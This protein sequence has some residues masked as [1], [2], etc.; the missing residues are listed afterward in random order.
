VPI[1]EEIAKMVPV[2]AWFVLLIRRGLEGAASD[3]AILGFAAGAGFTLHEDGLSGNPFVS[4]GGFLD[5]LPWSLVLPTMGDAGSS[6]ALNHGLWSAIVG[7]GVGLFFLLRHRAGAWVLPLVGVLLAVF[8]HVALN[9]LAG[10]PFLGTGRGGGEAGWAELVL[11]VTA[12]GL[13][14]LLALVIG[15]VITIVIET[16]ILS[17]ASEREPAFGAV[18]MARVLAERS[19]WRR[20]LELRTYERLRRR[21]FYAAWRA[22]RTRDVPPGAG[23]VVGELIARADQA[24]YLTVPPP[25]PEEPQAAAGSA[26]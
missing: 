13:V 19:D 1:V 25:G 17:W 16:R 7:L 15:L 9:A 21:A 26:V 24:G 2:V 6:L 20:V 23:L 22:E 12:G 3:G 10:D 11:A 14:P 4:G 18:P 8:N 5:A